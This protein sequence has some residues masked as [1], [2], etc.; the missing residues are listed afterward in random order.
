M[1]YLGVPE[2]ELREALLD[3]ARLR[4]MLAAYEPA[5]DQPASAVTPTGGDR[6]DWLMTRLRGGI[7]MKTRD[8]A[9]RILD[10]VKDLPEEVRADVVEALHEIA[11]EQ[12]RWKNAWSASTVDHDHKLREAM[13]R[14]E[15]CEHHGEQ[16]KQLSAQV[17]HFDESHRRADA[18][19][20]AL[21]GLLD[22]VRQFTE[23]YRAG[24]LAAD[25]SVADVVDALARS[26]KKTSA[27][28]NRAWKG[29]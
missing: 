8:A 27:A 6:R 22:A 13:A 24:R 9:Y 14:S 28:H 2:G 17:H 16:I 15:S 21:L 25:L 29:K 26:E 20:L 3:N 10:H 12:D 19:R 5:A 11:D 4:S 23:A 7:G 1:S 18:G